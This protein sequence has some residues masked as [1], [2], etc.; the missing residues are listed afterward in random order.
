[1]ELNDLRSLITVLSFFQ[2][3]LVVGGVLVFKDLHHFTLVWAETLGPPLGRA[4]Q[5]PVQARTAGAAEVR[6]EVHTSE[7]TCRVRYS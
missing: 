3:G 4:V 6:G 1:M 7:H 2:F 5:Q